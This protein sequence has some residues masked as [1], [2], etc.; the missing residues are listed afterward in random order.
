[1]TDKKDAAPPTKLNVNLPVDVALNLQLLS[2]ELDCSKK[3]V[4]VQAL[5]QYISIKN[6]EIFYRNEHPNAKL[7]AEVKLNSYE[8]KKRRSFASM[9]LY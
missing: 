3:E 9:M 5:R 2:E 1:M 6:R 7:S 4:V 8:G